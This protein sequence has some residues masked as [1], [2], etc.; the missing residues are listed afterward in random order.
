MP[1]LA[2]IKTPPFSPSVGV[3]SGDWYPSILIS[4]RGSVPFIIFDSER[5][6]KSN[7]WSSIPISILS[8]SI[9][10]CIEWMFR[11]KTE[12]D[13]SDVIFSF[14]KW[15]FNCFWKLLT[16]FI[17]LTIPHFQCGKG[18]N[19]FCPK[20]NHHF[21]RKIQSW[22]ILLHFHKGGPLRTSQT[23]KSHFFQTMSWGGSRYP[24]VVNP[25]VWCQ[26]E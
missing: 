26:S 6:I 20:T 18:C 5:Q 16:L 19:T 21:A 24:K 17:F 1:F 14:W 9:W 23:S 4:I 8:S 3:P 10:A 25:F 2:Y 7:L 22:S 12:K 13:F 15:K 11:W